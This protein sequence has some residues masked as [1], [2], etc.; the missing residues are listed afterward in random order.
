MSIKPK[1]YHRVCSDHVGCGAQFLCHGECN[2]EK[3]IANRTSCYCPQHAKEHSD[4]IH[5]SDE[6]CKTRFGDASS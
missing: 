3:K 2:S 6:K 5:K 4:V 1:V